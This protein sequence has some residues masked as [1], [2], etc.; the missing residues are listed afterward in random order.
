MFILYIAVYDT[1]LYVGGCLVNF[2]VLKHQASK[3]VDRIDGAHVPEL[4]KKIATHSQS[5]SLPTAVPH[6][7]PAAKEVRSAARF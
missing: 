5:L 1:V 3:V 7:P 4:T 6:Q 2:S